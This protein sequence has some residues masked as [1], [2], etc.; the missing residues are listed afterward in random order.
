MRRLGTPHG[1]SS[2]A[3]RLIAQNPQ[4]WRARLALSTPPGRR[5]GGTAQRSSC[6]ST[7]SPTTRTAS[8]STR[9]IWQA[10]LGARPRPAARPRATSTL[11]REAVFYLDPHVCVS[12]RY[13]S[14]ELLWQ[15]PQCHE[16]NT[17]VEERICT[18]EGRDS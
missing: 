5:S 4:D 6:C 14:T 3:E 7:R 15:C 12:C 1:S 13:R 16:W 17:F 11:T 9:Q 18:R 10:L 8:R 2:S